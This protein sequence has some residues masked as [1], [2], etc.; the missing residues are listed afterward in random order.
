MVAGSSVS[1]SLGVSAGGVSVGAGVAVCVV[2]GR[3]EVLT[4]LEPP[5]D[6]G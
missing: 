1:S 5:N 6:E 3:F 2:A 4:P